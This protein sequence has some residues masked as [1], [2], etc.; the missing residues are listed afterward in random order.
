[1]YDTENEYVIFFFCDKVVKFIF[2]AYIFF[3]SLRENT[4]NFNLVGHPKNVTQ[5]IVPP[6]PSSTSSS[7]CFVH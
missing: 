3:I 2:N 1:M 6:R 4:R 7:S 5:K